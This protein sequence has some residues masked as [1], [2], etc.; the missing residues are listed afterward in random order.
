ML[1]HTNAFTHNRF[2]RQTLLHTEAFT[3]RSFYTQKLLHTEAFTQTRLHTNPFTHRRWQVLLAWCQVA[4]T[5]LEGG[6]GE[7]WWGQ[8]RGVSELEVIFR[9]SNTPPKHSAIQNFQTKLRR[10]GFVTSYHFPHLHDVF[11]SLKLHQHEAGQ[12]KPVRI[13]GSAGLHLSQALRRPSSPRLVGMAAFGTLT[14]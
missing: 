6:Q 4:N 12:A 5:T 9:H 11:I 10:P 13:Y 7:R 3:Q 2:Y 1:L 14:E 8:C